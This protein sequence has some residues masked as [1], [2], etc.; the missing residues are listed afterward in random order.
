MLEPLLTLP[1]SEDEVQ[2]EALPG[3]VVPPA[4]AGPGHVLPQ[5]RSQQGRGGEGAEEPPHQQQR[6]EEE[7][8]KEVEKY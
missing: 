5:V 3:A 8:V 4:G 6:T 1:E 2:E 7:E